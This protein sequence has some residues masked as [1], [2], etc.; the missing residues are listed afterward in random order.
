[1]Q[2]VR[3]TNINTKLVE[4]TPLYTSLNCSRCCFGPMVIS[5]VLSCVKLQVVLGHPSFNCSQ[6]GFNLNLAG[7]VRSN[8][9]VDLSVIGIAVKTN[10]LNASNITE[11]KHLGCKERGESKA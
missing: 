3:K 4:I 8:T 7:V 11:S 6:A 5:S 1:M 10:S 9:N 2:K